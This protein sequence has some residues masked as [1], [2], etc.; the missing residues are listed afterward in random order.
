MYITVGIIVILMLVMAVFLLKGKGAFLIAGYNTASAEV[1]SRYDE[2]ALC[3]FIGWLL[4]AMSFCMLLFPAGQYFQAAW[5]TYCAIILI[6]LGSIGAVV[7][8]NTGN[9]FRKNVD[10]KVPVAGGNTNTNAS[11][12]K[13]N[14]I[15]VTLIS[16]IVLMAVGISLYQGGK[17]PVVRIVDSSVQIKAMYGLSVGFAD[18][19]DVSLIEKSMSEIG[20]GKRTDGYGGIGEAL[21]GHFKA[22]NLGETLLF[23][24]SKCTPTIRIERTN[25]K[26]IYIS[27]KNGETTQAVYREIVASIP[28]K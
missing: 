5:L 4:I 9:R 8:A 23:V 7:Y 13:A 6:T 27:F 21:K 28:A 11:T 17:D 18:I 15:V 19:T 3:R 1:K 24:Q 12:A 22:D 20:V 25:E 14:I 26:D 2:K 10:D 16:A